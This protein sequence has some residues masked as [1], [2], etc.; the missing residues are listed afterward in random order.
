MK[1]RH[2]EDRT[3]T[4]LVEVACVPMCE[5]CARAEHS[6]GFLVLRLTEEDFKEFS[7]QTPLED[8]HNWVFCDLGFCG[9][10]DPEGALEMLRDTLNL[11]NK[12]FDERWDEI[13]RRF[14]D[15]PM[16]WTYLYFL[17]DK[18]LTDHG[19]NIRG[20]WL[21]EKGKGILAAL[22]AYTIEQIIEGDEGAESIL[23]AKVIG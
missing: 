18:G 16:S 15:N 12:E 11:L 5:E 23:D 3:A 1:C 13:K 22:N 7:A 4:H 2:H 14:P 19:S 17:D 8:L 9:C 21:T 10:G 6:N 20:C